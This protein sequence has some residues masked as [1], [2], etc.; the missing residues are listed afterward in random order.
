MICK[1]GIPDLTVNWLKLWKDSWLYLW[2]SQTRSYFTSRSWKFEHYPLKC[3]YEWLWTVVWLSCTE[4]W[5][6]TCLFDGK[7]FKNTIWDLLRYMTASVLSSALP[8]VTELSAFSLTIPNNQ[9][10]LSLHSLLWRGRGSIISC[11]S[12]TL[13]KDWAN[14]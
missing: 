13:R 12:F 6:F 1:L 11:E 10:Q 3:V 7:M 9:C 5:T 4:N 14:C 8:E 2:N